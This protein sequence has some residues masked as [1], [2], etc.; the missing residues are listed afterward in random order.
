VSVPRNLL[1]DLDGTLTD[2]R[3]GIVRCFQHALRRLGAEVPEEAAL[4]RHIGPPLRNALRE[5]LPGREAEI[6]RAV[7]AYRERFAPIGMF[8]NRVYTG[9][10]E[11][12]KALVQAGNTLHLCTSKPRPFARRILEHFGLERYFASIHGSELDGTR[13]DKREL[14]V[15]L[16]GRERLT[17]AR[18]L[19]LGDRHFDVEA[20][21][22]CG[23]AS[24]GVLWGYGSREELE[25]AG[26]AWLAESPEAL[27]ALLVSAP[28]RA[29]G[30]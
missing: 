10:P 6:E 18:C 28:E 22:H 20:A 21:S 24:V 11:L 26:A 8:E 19:M 25:A 29:S 14:L 30:A 23:V 1:F 5:L 7:E 9:I 3:E 17:P 15:Y 13:N 4:E 27:R 2:P 12:L 16:L